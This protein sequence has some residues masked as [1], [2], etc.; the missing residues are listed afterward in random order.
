[1]LSIRHLRYNDFLIWPVT[2]KYALQLDWIQLRRID[3]LFFDKSFPKL[4][5]LVALPSYAQGVPMP[6][7]T[8][9]LNENQNISTW[10]PWSKGD[11]FALVSVIVAV[12]TLIT[13]FFLPK[14]HRWLFATFECKLNASLF[15]KSLNMIHL[16]P[17]STSLPFV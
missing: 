5:L 3:C 11:I 10:K 12:L 9:P 16:L 8:T 7:A 15:M 2:Q 4:F 14:L 1:M 17:D 13:A 6:N